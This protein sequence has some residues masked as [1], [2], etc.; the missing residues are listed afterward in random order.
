MIIKILPV[1]AVLFFSSCCIQGKMDEARR[2]IK[3]AKDTLQVE[4]QNLSKT[5]ELS[6]NKIAD[7]K[8]D[9]TILVLISKRLS[10]FQ[11]GMDT[12]SINISSIESLLVDVKAFRKKY[13]TIIAPTLEL[14]KKSTAAYQQKSALYEMIGDGL[15]IAD[16]KL[17]DLAAFFGPGKYSVPDEKKESASASFSPIVDSIIQFSNKYKN[18]PRTGSLI[19]L[20]FADGTGFSEGPLYTLLAEKIGIT[21]PSKEQLNQKLSELRAEELIS[22]LSDQIKKKTLQIQSSQ[23]LKVD[24]LQQG[25]GENLPLPTVKNYQVNDERRRIVLCY[26][27]ILPD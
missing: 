9:S 20:G 26:W 13:K 16:Y 19:I 24:Y 1:V 10:R 15:N 21:N 17:F 25:K 12:A 7:G 14:L 8:I 23:T 2:V 11:S 4:T 5:N 27:T 3:N 18:I 22:L 6:K